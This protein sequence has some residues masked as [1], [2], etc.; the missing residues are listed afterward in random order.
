MIAII[1]NVQNRLLR[2]GCDECYLKLLCRLSSKIRWSETL[3][4]EN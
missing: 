4:I 3:R 2:D 1:G